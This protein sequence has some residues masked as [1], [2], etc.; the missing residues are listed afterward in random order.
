[1]TKD[2]LLEMA[3]LISSMRRGIEAVAVKSAALEAERNELA[4]HVS[5]H[6]DALKQSNAQCGDYHKRIERLTDELSA[7][8]AERD[9]LHD[10]AE[11]LHA[12][13]VEVRAAATLQHLSQAGDCASVAGDISGAG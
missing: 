3:E 9:T 4:A 11:K 5:A 13:L 2:T 10:Y 8:N 7:S 1:M 12:E 6:V